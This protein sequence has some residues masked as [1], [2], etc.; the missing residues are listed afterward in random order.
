[1][2]VLSWKKA[3]DSSSGFMIRV[4]R[5]EALRIISSLSSQLLTSN[6][7]SSRAEFFTEKGEYFSIAVAE[8]E[9]NLEA[10]YD[11]IQR[12]S[13]SLNKWNLD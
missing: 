11:E 9:K 12:K 1:M 8:K 10:V 4:S 6:P 3:K 5:N 2:E 13:A 7:N